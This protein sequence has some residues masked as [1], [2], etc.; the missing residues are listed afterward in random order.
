M[1]GGIR[2]ITDLKIALEKIQL[3]DRQLAEVSFYNSHKVRAPLARLMGLVQVLCLDH[4][5]SHEELLQ[6][7][8]NIK[9]SAEELDYL[10]KNINQTLH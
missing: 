9:S 10:I 2:D 5:T 8:D 3:R 6:L 1:V 4:D 7:L